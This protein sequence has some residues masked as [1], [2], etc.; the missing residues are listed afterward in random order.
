MLTSHSWVHSIPPHPSLWSNLLFYYSKNS[1]KILINTLDHIFL[2]YVKTFSSIVQKQFN[3][4]YFPILFRI[5]LCEG[6]AIS[7]SLITLILFGHSF[8]SKSLP[9]EN[10]RND[11]PSKS[12]SANFQSLCSA[13]SF[14]KE[15]LDRNILMSWI[16]S[17]S[18]MC[19]KRSSP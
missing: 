4:I 18:S 15:V 2:K 5:A 11:L 19:P 14:V 10:F 12:F 9:H 7:I 3:N 8:L 16:F 17:T 1:R 6:S 13:N